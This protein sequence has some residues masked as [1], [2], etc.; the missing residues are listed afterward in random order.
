MVTDR[1]DVCIPW[2]TL[3]AWQPTRIIKI[4][5]KNEVIIA[6]NWVVRSREEVRGQHE[7]SQRPLAR[8]PF[9]EARLCQLGAE[10]NGRMADE[11]VDKSLAERGT[12]RGLES[13]HYTW[14]WLRE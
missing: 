5:E 10:L 4:K 2:P 12:G 13:E 7:E 8:L 9:R 6:A 11:R 3:A 1:I 14:N